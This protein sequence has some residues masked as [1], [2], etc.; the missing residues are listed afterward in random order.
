MHIGSVAFNAI[1][2]EQAKTN[3]SLY[4][5]LTLANHLDTALDRLLKANK[6]L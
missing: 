4:V 6:P 5:L 2:I 1:K 3:P